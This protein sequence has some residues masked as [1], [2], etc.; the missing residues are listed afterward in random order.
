MSF[1][2]TIA[3]TV[4]VI[5]LTMFYLSKMSKTKEADKKKQEEIKHAASEKVIGPERKLHEEEKK[6]WEDKYYKQH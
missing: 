6:R 4:F 3:I 1:I 5:I 2:L